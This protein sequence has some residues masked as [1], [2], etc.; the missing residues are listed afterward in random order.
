[1]AMELVDGPDGP[2][3]EGTVTFGPAYEGPPGHAH[4]G[5]VAAMFDELLGRG[6]NQPGFTAWLHVEYRKPT[7][8]ELPLTLK[9]WRDRTERRKIWI[10]GECWAGGMLL[11][12]AEGLFIAPREG[13]HLGVLEAARARMKAATGG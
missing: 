6:L 3:V 8:L 2:V 1:M 13:D 4:G 10:K 9:A 12:E 7:P 5:Y 11:T